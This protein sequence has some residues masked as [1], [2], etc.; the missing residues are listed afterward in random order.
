MPAGSAEQSMGGYGGSEG[1]TGCI[2]G[3]MLSGGGDGEANR[4]T[5]ALFWTW[6][7]ASHHGYAPPPPLQ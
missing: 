4:G 3:V 6:Q 7:Q 1:G 2:G 5:H